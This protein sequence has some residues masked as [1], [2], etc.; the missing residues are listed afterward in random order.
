MQTHVDW[1]PGV[2]LL[3]HINDSF[4]KTANT[5]KFNHAAYKTLYLYFFQCEQADV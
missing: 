5:D 3:I 4:T 1:A 2:D